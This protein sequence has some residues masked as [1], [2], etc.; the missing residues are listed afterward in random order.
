MQKV[1]HFVTLILINQEILIMSSERKRCVENFPGNLILRGYLI[2]YFNVFQIT[3]HD[4]FATLK[5]VVGA[6]D[7][8]WFQ[9]KIIRCGWFSHYL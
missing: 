4:C 7:V 9:A 2:H 5:T 3:L 8:I 1:S 6:C